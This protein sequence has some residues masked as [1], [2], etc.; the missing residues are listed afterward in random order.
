MS[1]KD[2]F[3]IRKRAD[4]SFTMSYLMVYELA[5]RN[6][7]ISFVNSFLGL[8]WT[9]LTRE[10]PVWARLPTDPLLHLASSWSISLEET[11]ERFLFIATS[12]LFAPGKGVPE[13]EIVNGAGPAK[14]ADGTVE[15]EAISSIGTVK[16]LGS[17]L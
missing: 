15:E 10:L 13:D 16:L 17:Q 4:Y 11:S 6:S 5:S 12:G 2:I 8:A 14:G 1:L 9:A 7:E 3:S